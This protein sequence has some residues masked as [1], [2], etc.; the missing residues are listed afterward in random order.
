M[1]R[2]RIA[3][4][5][6]GDPHVGTLY[7]ALFNMAFA[8]KEKGEFILRI[9]DTDKKRSDQLFEDNIYKSLQWADIQWDEGPDIGGKY[10]PYRQS[11]RLEIYEKYIQVLLDKGVAYKCFA[12]KKEL[13]EM[14]ELSLKMGKKAGYDRRY[15]NLSEEEVKKRLDNNE[16]YVVRLKV[17][18]TGICEFSDYV[19]GK[20]SVPMADIDD[21]VLMKADGYPTY[22]F[23]NVVDDYLMKITHVIRGDEWIS[24]SAKHVLLYEAF[25]WD[26]PVFVHIPLLI[27]EDKRKLSKRR[28]PTSIFY[29]K[30]S[31]YLPKALI[32]F[33]SLMGYSMGKEKEIYSMQDLIDSFDL[34]KIGTSSAFFDIRK[35]NWVN[36]KYIMQLSEDQLLSHLKE[37][38]F[39]DGFFNKLMPLVHTRMQTLSDFM[40]M[41]Y[42][43]FAN[44][45]PLSK[46]LLCPKGL[47]ELE[48]SYILQSVIWFLEKDGRWNAESME[49]SS[50]EV[51]KMFNVNHKKVV[52]Q[53]LFVSIM[54]KKQGLPLFGSIN[55]L[56]K[57]RT[58]ARL[59]QAIK[60]LI[61]GVP[62][63]KMV[64]LKKCFEKNDC[65]DLINGSQ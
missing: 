46:E 43:L 61:G 4:S 17:P 20:I 64:I 14:R 59:L 54:G 63:K 6:T 24:S 41:G 23:A 42:F 60:F 2:T 22:H 15:R 37:W 55:I 19:K 32:N 9:E 18:L 25:G 35:L 29:Y 52:M 47:T 51:A 31:G 21:Q 65:S 7:V 49:V 56:K 53:I 27:G 57:E 26:R 38:Q 28:N 12:T 48:S 39:N 40:Q 3:P 16:K 33:L 62:N 36:Q 8:K 5:P 1:I 11:E 45:I 58:R 44:E 13:E 50:K 30:D 10:G 34:S